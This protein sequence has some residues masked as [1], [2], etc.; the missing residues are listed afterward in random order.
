MNLSSELTA[1]AQYLTGEFTNQ[2]QAIAEPAWYVH[3]RLWHQPVSLFTED[4][5]TLFAEQANILK[6]DQP[7]RQRLI[8]I[9]QHPN[10]ASLQMQYYMPQNPTA[11]RGAGAN[12]TV[13]K[14]LTPNDFELLP[15]CLLDVTVNQL[16]RDCYHFK[17]TLPSDRRCCFSYAGNTVQVS[18]GFEATPEEFLSYDKGIDSTTGKAT[19]GAILGPYRF[20]KERS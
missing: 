15:G 20:R 9:Q 11:L 13:L 4:S 1:I 16:E 2:E 8:R 12:P 6:L 7:Y 14:T 10:K 18:I 5:F 19:W 17:A 3:L